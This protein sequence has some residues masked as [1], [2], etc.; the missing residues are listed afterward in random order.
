VGVSAGIAYGVSYLSRQPR[1][2]LKVVTTYAR[3]HRYMGMRNLADKNNRSYFG[4]KFAYDTIP[5]QL[6]PFDY[7]AFEAWPGQVEAVVTNL[8]T[9]KA[10]YF[11]VPRRDRESTL[12]Q[13]TC[14]MPLMFPIYHLGGQPYLD[15]GIGD[16]IPWKH[17]L[18][19]GCDR[20]LVVLTH[21]RD[22][23]RKPDPMQKLLH[24]TY[25]DYPN[26]LHVMEHRAHVYNENREELFQLE[27][28]GKVKVILP[29]STMGVSR[30]EKD[31]EKLRLLWAKGYQMA[32]DRME[33][34][35]DY[36]SD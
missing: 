17:A 22:Y 5:N 15:G 24:R 6:I 23:V 27:R 18:E 26:F 33:E 11:P 10:E 28:Q 36:F 1:R 3:D 4:L 34:L 8:N 30:T 13:A 14:A 20:L 16:A 35:K 7:D 12:L 9:G 31:P 32:V 25:R 29:D 21:P 2:N 19:Q